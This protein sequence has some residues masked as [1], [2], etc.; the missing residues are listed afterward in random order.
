MFSRGK[1]NKP[2]QFKLLNTWQSH[3]GL[4]VN[5][6]FINTLVYLLLFEHRCSCLQL[7]LS[8]APIVTHHHINVL[9]P[10]SLSKMGHERTSRS[11]EHG[12][13]A[14]LSLQ[15][16]CRQ[17]WRTFYR[18]R[19]VFFNGKWRQRLCENYTVS[20]VANMD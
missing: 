1:R 9:V 10:G 20:C 8:N 12:T 7:E 16:E 18:R 11:D 3:P 6:M 4:L 17:E 19:I 2:N 14:R 13:S 15:H 5:A